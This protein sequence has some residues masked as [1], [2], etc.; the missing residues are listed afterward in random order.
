MRRLTADREAWAETGLAL[1]GLGVLGGLLALV[2]GRLSGDAQRGS[3]H[4]EAPPAPGNVPDARHQ[5]IA[6]PSPR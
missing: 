1:L 2:L 4:A 5:N 3:R 6:G